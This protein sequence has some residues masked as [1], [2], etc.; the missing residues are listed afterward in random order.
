MSAISEQK[1]NSSAKRGKVESQNFMVLNVG[2]AETQHLWGCDDLSSPFARIYYVVEG[3]ATLHLPQGDVVARPGHMYMI[4]TFIP[5]SYVCQPGFRFYYLFVYERFREKSD[6]FDQREFP[7][8][9]KANEAADLLFRNFCHL[10]PNLSL[11]YADSDAFNTHPS[12]KAYA[13]SYMNLES[14]EHLQLQGLVWIIFSYFMKHSRPKYE[15]TDERMIRVAQYLQD[16]IGE[17]ISVDRLADVACV[18]KPH[19]SRLCHKSF[20]MSPIKYVTRKKVQYAQELL[21]TTDLSVQRI[22]GTVG[23]P[24]TSYFIRVFRKHI[25]FTPQD[26]RERLK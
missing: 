22:A 26:Y 7:I 9:V 1:E 4:P 15:V 25:G 24:D 17:D 12:Y 10:Y 18:A 11:P 3:S 14:Y 16:H 2:Y 21:L 5:H 19:L 20:G 6:I 13:E 23:F 8:E